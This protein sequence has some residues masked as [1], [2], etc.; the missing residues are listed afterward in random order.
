MPQLV[1]WLLALLGL[2]AGGVLIAL[3]VIGFLNPDKAQRWAEMLWALVSKVWRGGNSWAVKYG[4][5]SRLTGFA[6]EVASETG[7]GEPASVKVEWAPKEEQPNQFIADG[8]VVIRLHAYEQQDRNLVTASLL[9]VSSQ[10]VRR[11][12]I[13]LPKKRARSVDLYA[14]DRLLTRTAPAAADLLHEE[15]MG[16]ECDADHELGDLLVDYQKIDRINGFFPVFIRELNYLAGKVIVKPRGDQLVKDVN[17]LHRFLVRYSDRT[18]GEEG[19]LEVQGRFLRCAVAIVAKSFKREMGDRDPFVKYLRTLASAG[20]ETIYLIGN[21]NP[22]NREFMR[23]I[24]ADFRAASGWSEVDQRTYPAVI[25]L[26]DGRDS[27]VQNRLIVLRTNA[28]RDYVG[29][30]EEVPGLASEEE[31]ES[32]NGNDPHGA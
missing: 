9:F 4:T 27:Q 11:A 10:L 18:I 6:I 28:P 17:E 19:V 26:P 31:L 8:R 20:H 21:D 3:L 16:P 2:G 14:T 30:A 23:A 24:A 1:A 15:V 7:K 13:Y 22:D 12:K 29:V 32:R 25:H 5:Q